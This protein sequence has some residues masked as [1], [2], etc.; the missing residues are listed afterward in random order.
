MCKSPTQMTDSI[1]TGYRKYC[2]K[3]C[4]M[5]NAQL[6][7]KNTP[8]SLETKHKI[9]VGISNFLK[10][11]RGQKYLKSLSVSRRGK[12]NPIHRQSIEVK[13]RSRKK[14]S[15]TIKQK[16]KNGEFTPCITNSWCHSRVEVNGIPFRS[17]WEAVFYILNPHLKYEKIR[18]PYIDC[19]G[20]CK[21]YIVD[22]VDDENKIIYEIKP[23]SVRDRPDNILKEGAAMEWCDA[24]GYEYICISDEYYMKNA[25]NVDYTLVD[26]KIKKSMKQFLNEN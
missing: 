6:I 10:T 8:M 4:C 22:F 24:N 14:Q 23:N 19:S 21:V 2:S 1:N 13:E 17:C 25:I 26:N 3:L 16:I 11:P 7:S 9:K 15:E 18:I 20:N 12:N 5:K